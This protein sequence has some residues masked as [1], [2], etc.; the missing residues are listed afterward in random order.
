MDQGESSTAFDIIAGYRIDTVKP[1][2]NHRADQVLVASGPRVCG[3]SAKDGSLKYVLR[4][5]ES[6]SND[7]ISIICRKNSDHICVCTSGGDLEVWDIKLQRFI[8]KLKFCS[9]AESKVTTAAIFDYGGGRKNKT[10]IYFT[11]EH[12]KHPCLYFRE[13]S[14]DNPQ[15]EPSSKKAKLDA[16]DNRRLA[17][18]SRGD[19]QSF[20]SSFAAS[21]NLVSFIN[22]KQMCGCR[23][24]PTKAGPNHLSEVPFT[25]VASHPNEDIA[26]TGNALGQVVIWNN[27]IDTSKPIKSVSHWHPNPLADVCFSSSGTK[28]YSGGQEAVIA[29][30]EIQTGHKLLLPRIGS[31]IKFLNGDHHQY[32]ITTLT[33]NSVHIISTDIHKS[34][35]RIVSLIESVT[36]FDAK[37]LIAYHE[38]L[39][40][41][42][43]FGRPGH[44]QFLSVN[45]SVPRQHFDVVG[46]NLFPNEIDQTSNPEVWNFCMSPDGNWLVTDDGR[47][48]GIN[49]RE[50][51]LKFWQF[52]ELKRTFVT[53]TLVNH[54]HDQKIISITFSHDSKKVVTTSDDGT[55]KLWKLNDDTNSWGS[56]HH[57][58]SYNGCIPTDSCFS[59]DSSIIAVLFG[60]LLNFYGVSERILEHHDVSLSHPADSNDQVS[61]ICFGFNEFS[62]LFVDIKGKSIYVWDLFD[63][64]V[65]WSYL[66]PASLSNLAIDASSNQMSCFSADNCVLLFSFRH[67]TPKIISTAHLGLG[68]DWTIKP[69]FMSKPINNSNLILLTSD[70]QIISVGNSSRCFKPI[71]EG[72]MEGV[73][74]ARMFGVVVGGES[75][76]VPMTLKR[77]YIPPFNVDRL[78]DQIFLKNPSHTLP[79][80]EQLCSTFMTCLVSGINI[81]VE[82]DTE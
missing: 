80:I 45:R 50:D 34:K 7:V 43:T 5:D 73:D 82:D 51:R 46:R 38:T 78:V 65:L 39:N 69:F 21:G 27:F 13:I 25:C 15:S 42:V 70:H 66:S 4:K 52:D 2:F 8:S 55:F 63:Q 6:K 33:D 54:P 47:D 68:W 41:I 36:P 40:C 67:Q 23:L 37:P 77:L 22:G 32:V 10:F 59:S 16:P 56:H 31:P 11:L 44:L 20:Q 75:K 58:V 81:K 35:N 12:E 26:A 14:I 1:T 57:E 19:D 62:H 28:L 60:N 64:K 71:R 24:P 18:F 49:L 76:V 29:L 3:Y 61:G 53:K 48:D 30:W 74:E 17:I 72:T 79:P 9:G